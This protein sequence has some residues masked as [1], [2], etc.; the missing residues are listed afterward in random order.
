M[1][2]IDK[3]Q[4][5][6]SSATVAP[7]DAKWHTISAQQISYRA[8]EISLVLINKNRKTRFEPLIRIR[9][10]WAVIRWIRPQ[11]AGRRGRHRGSEFQEGRRASRIIVNEVTRKKSCEVAGYRTLSDQTQVR[12]SPFLVDERR[13]ELMGPWR[14]NLRI[15][16][17]ENSS[18]RDGRTR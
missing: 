3:K 6:L 4:L 7:R 13:K 18:K 1:A 15:E 12:N 8:T 17:H 2:R 14:N 5:K 9:L 11:K 16:D 10:V